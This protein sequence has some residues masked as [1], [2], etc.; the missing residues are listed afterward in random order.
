MFKI[1]YWNLTTFS[2]YAFWVDVTAFTRSWEQEQ[3]GEEN[4]GDKPSIDT[5]WRRDILLVIK[6][7]IQYAQWQLRRHPF[8]STCGGRPANLREA[9]FQSTGL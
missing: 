7:E 4:K 3:T 5:I 6:H 1:T 8:F 9:L 2:A